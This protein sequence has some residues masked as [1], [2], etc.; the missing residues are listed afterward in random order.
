[1]KRATKSQNKIPK[2]FKLTPSMV[3]AIE[4]EAA[5]TSRTQTKVVELALAEY[6]L[7]KR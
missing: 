3:A 6:F 4:K 1:M 7:V 2:L 5:K